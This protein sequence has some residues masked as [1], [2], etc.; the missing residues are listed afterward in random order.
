[1]VNSREKSIKD[2][3]GGCEVGLG[4]SRYDVGFRDA[5]VRVAGMYGGAGIVVTT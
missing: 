5:V 2:T 1:M 4:M 3:A